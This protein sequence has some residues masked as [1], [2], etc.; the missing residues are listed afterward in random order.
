MNKKENPW[1]SLLFNLALPV[2]LLNYGH[3]WIPALGPAVITVLALSFPLGYGLWDYFKNDKRKNLLSIFGAVNV[4]FTGGFALLHLEGIWFAVK[5]AVFPLLIGLWCFSTAFTKT[6][7]VRWI[8]HRS[9]FFKVSAIQAQLTTKEKQESYENILKKSTM[10]FSLCFFISAVLNFV[11]ALNIF[12]DHSKQGAA[13][14][15]ILNEQ[16]ADMTWIS[17]LVIGLP[18]TIITGIVL[19]RLLSQL[20]QL[21]SLSVEQILHLEK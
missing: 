15:Q 16:I 13:Q 12:Q 18:L 21:T 6:P 4:L 19:W 9:S 5:E 3:K 8:V 17:F 11:L 7:V 20:R 2:C 10:Y 14:Q 1:I